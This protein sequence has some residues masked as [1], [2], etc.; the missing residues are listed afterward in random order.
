MEIKFEISSRTRIER[1]E[2]LSQY[3]EKITY[4]ANDCTYASDELLFRGHSDEDYEL[5]PALARRT[6]VDAMG[7]P[8]EVFLLEYEQELIEGAKKKY[9]NIF[10]DE[11][12]PINLLAKLQHHG[13]P[14]RLLDVTENPLVALFFACQE[15]FEKDG[16]VF[17][18]QSKV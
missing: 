6:I 4:F 7:T 11:K 12:Y 17:L 3:I 14:T 10:H 13:I 15:S 2:N 16:E 8:Y 1:I 5:L 18:F 9:P